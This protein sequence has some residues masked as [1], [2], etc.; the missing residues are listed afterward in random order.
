V[1]LKYLLEI[2]VKQC[3]ILPWKKIKSMGYEKKNRLIFELNLN[4]LNTHWY[5]HI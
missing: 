1:P 2:V 5:L 3:A 4:W